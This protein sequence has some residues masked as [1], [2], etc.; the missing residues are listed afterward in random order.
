MSRGCPQ[1]VPIIRTQ[2]SLD[3]LHDPS[4]AQAAEETYP[5]VCD[6]STFDEVMLQNPARQSNHEVLKQALVKLRATRK[7]IFPQHYSCHWGTSYINLFEHGYPAGC[8][9]SLPLSFE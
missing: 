1:Y 7:R 3:A 8:G 6:L 5:E 9:G 2:N 4:E